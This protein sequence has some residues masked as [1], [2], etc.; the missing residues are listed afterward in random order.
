[1]FQCEA[2]ALPIKL[3][4]SQPTSFLFYPSVC[5]PHHPAG[6]WASSCVGLRCLQSLNHGSQAI[7]M[8]Y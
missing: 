6:Q 3:S 5:L 8:L 7:V 4:L 1:L 2:F